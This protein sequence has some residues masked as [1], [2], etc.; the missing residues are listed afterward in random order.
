MKILEINLPDKAYSL[1]EDS[2]VWAKQ[3]LDDKNHRDKR[4]VYEDC[5]IRPL[6]VLKYQD[7][8]LIGL[9]VTSQDWNKSKFAVKIDS[10]YVLCDKIKE[11]DIHYDFPI[12]D[13]EKKEFKKDKNGNLII[14]H[15]SVES[16]NVNLTKK[17]IDEI[18]NK[19][20]EYLNTLKELSDKK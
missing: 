19:H 8:K 15:H 11:V 2:L 20:Q 6:F 16:V 3:K 18:H 5:E 12:V 13:K 14:K 10:G 9:D 1:Y 4:Y 17:E 7:S